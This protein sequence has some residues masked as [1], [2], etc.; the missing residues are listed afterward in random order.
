MQADIYHFLYESSVNHTQL[1]L[2]PL[3]SYIYMC[4][5]YLGIM[6]R[7]FIKRRQNKLKPEHTILEGED[8]PMSTDTQGNIAI[9][10]ISTS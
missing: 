1:N 5:V 3:Q 2:E 8:T 9:F 10:A 7:T 6:L 4:I